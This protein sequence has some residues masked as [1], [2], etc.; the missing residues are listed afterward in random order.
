MRM[1]P[2]HDL[3]GSLALSRS[4]CSVIKLLSAR[5]PAKSCIVL[6]RMQTQFSG[7]LSTIKAAVQA[8]VCSL[9]AWITAV[10]CKVRQV[11]VCQG[12]TPV[13]DML[14]A[15]T[16][17]APCPA[18]GDCSWRQQRVLGRRHQQEHTGQTRSNGRGC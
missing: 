8:G 7:I 18:A 14:P 10:C 16:R 1:R 15:L 2:M 17:L 9:L 13:A 12:W 4:S 11:P 3:A 5:L 6:M